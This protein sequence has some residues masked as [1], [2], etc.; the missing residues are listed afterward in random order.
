MNNKAL[1]WLLYFLV[2]SVNAEAEQLR[3]ITKSYSVTNDNGIHQPSDKINM[4]GWEFEV[5][6]VTGEI[7]GYLAGNIKSLNKKATVVDPGRPEMS[8]SIMTTRGGEFGYLADL[9]TIKTWVG[10]LNKPF[11]LFISG[12]GFFSGTCMRL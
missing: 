1:I 7:T 9:L 5:N 12:F 10:K 8:V 11:E 3:C 4:I 2:F 6:V